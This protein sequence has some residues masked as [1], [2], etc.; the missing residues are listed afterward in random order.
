M[1]AVKIRF[2]HLSPAAVDPVLVGQGLR[3]GYDPA[4]GHVGRR[5]AVLPR[6]AVLGPDSG[7]VV[8]PVVHRSAVWLVVFP[9]KGRAGGVPPGAHANDGPGALDDEV[10]PVPV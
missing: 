1:S 8:V 7:P 4:A 3:A 10:P 6:P 2:G 9:V 5:V